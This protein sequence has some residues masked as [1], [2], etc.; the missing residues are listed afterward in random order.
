MLGAEL[1]E[2]WIFGYGTASA[3]VVKQQLPD[4]L[5]E[6]CQLHGGLQAA[7]S[8]RRTLTLAGARWAL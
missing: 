6:V 5:H 7:S 3:T 8:G 1:E 2:I 4:F